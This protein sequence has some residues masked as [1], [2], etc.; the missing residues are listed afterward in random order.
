M[1]Q[2]TLADYP[3]FF[4]R[5]LAAVVTPK[6]LYALLL[7]PRPHR[8]RRP[9]GRL[10]PG[11]RHLQGTAPPARILV[12]LM[13]AG[14][15]KALAGDDLYSIGF[16]HTWAVFPLALLA[17]VLLYK[18]WHLLAFALVGVIFNLHALT[19]GYLLAM[20]LAWAVVDYRVPGWRWKL[21]LM[22]G[23]FAAIASPTVLEISAPPGVRPRVA[24]GPRTRIRSADHSFP[25]S[26]WT[27]GSTNL[28][29]PRP[30]ARTRRR[31]P[32]VPRPQ[33]P[34]PSPGKSLLLA[35]GVGV[36]FLIG[37]VFADVWPVA[38]VIRAD[39]P[40]LPS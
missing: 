6:N 9:L 40:Q 22:L 12:V 28:P 19:A 16:T 11:P 20:F 10:R 30:P 1:V 35:A 31:L 25:S 18:E 23:V 32:F 15:H 27:T 39:F 29:R 34:R 21:A 2:E 14:H 38:T 17:L 26:W 7:A 5:M 13:L 8:C 24:G 37:Y 4:F 3:S 36:L 33:P